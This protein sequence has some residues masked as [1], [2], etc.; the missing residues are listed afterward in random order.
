MAQSLKVCGGGQCG[1]AAQ[2]RVEMVSG[3]QQ[4]QHPAEAVA[5]H[6]DLL[7]LRDLTNAFDGGRQVIVGVVVER[8]AG[9]ALIG[10]SAYFVGAALG[11]GLDGR[12]SRIQ[13]FSSSEPESGG[14]I[15]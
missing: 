5:E 14:R 15:P 11:V 13:R 8:V 4:R 6:V 12:L 1:Q 9:I 3:V 2:R 7:V 10:N